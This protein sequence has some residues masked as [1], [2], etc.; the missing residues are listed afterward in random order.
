MAPAPVPR[1]PS[2]KSR[3]FISGPARRGLTR[4]APQI[5]GLGS[6]R[7]LQIAAIETAKQAQ[8]WFVSGWDRRVNDQYT[9]IKVKATWHS[10]LGTCPHELRTPALGTF[11][12]AVEDHKVLELHVASVCCLGK[13]PSTFPEMP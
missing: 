7:V 11:Q 8:S 12:G 1:Q 3:S 5:G 10:S 4:P 6:K 9:E 2:P 13:S